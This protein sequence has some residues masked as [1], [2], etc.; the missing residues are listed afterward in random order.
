LRK[1]ALPLA[2]I[3]RDSA[4]AAC[5]SAFGIFSSIPRQD[6]GAKRDGVVDAGRL[7]GLDATLSF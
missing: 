4:I 3:A 7:G 1:L 5:V 2:I 6:T